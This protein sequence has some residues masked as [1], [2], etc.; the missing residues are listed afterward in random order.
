VDR[1]VGVGGDG[2]HGPELEA[3]RQLR[4]AGDGAVVG[5]GRRGRQR[6][7]KQQDREQRVGGSHRRNLVR[8]GGTA[9]V[10]VPHAAANGSRFRR[11]G[12]TG[13]ISLARTAGEGYGDSTLPIY[14]PAPRV[15]HDSET[16]PRLHAD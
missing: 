13:V 9:T 14:L 1:A 15:L 4:P 10:S 6:D 16:A 8:G 3:V 5:V 7:G 2:G 12:R 11:P